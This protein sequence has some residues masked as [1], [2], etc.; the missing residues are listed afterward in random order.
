MEIEFIAS[1][2]K[3]I[4][5]DLN[6]LEEEI[7]LYSTEEAIWKIDKEIKNSAGNLCLHLCGNLQHF[8]GAILGKSGYVRNRENEFAAKG[9]SKAKLVAEIQQTKK[10]V[11]SAL[12]GLNSSVL[13]EEYQIQVFGYPMTTMYFLIHLSAHL[14]YHLGQV[15]YHRRLLS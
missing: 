3:L 6:K 13:L 14:E 15:N 4:E 1:I 11:K 7:K 8:I 5:R 9:I 2:D 10:A 12:Q